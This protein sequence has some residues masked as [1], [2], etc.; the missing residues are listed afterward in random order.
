M[1]SDVL[2]SWS[3]PSPRASVSSGGMPLGKQ[4][5]KSLGYLALLAFY[6]EIQWMFMAMKLED[7]PRSSARK[8]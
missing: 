7:W 4:A 5:M 1:A 2:S 3:C 6:S 8:N